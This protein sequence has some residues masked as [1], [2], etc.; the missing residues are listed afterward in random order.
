MKIALLHG[1]LVNSGDFLIAQRSKELLKFIY[2][3]ALITEYYRN[4]SI[5]PYLTDINNHNIMIIAGGPVYINE[6]Y[7]EG[8]LLIP[9]LSL[10]KIPIMFLGMGWWGPTNL[11]T[12][13]YNY[14][15]SGP[16]LD[17]L[18]RASNDTKCLTCRDNLTTSVIRINGFD[19]VIDF[20]LPKQPSFQF[21]SIDDK[22][23]ATPEVDS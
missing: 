23:N 7:P 6:F 4:Q 14:S 18:K 21:T 11:P 12:V 3:D 10:I 2:T 15:F 22:A 8:S 16:M 19:N 5:E 13:M 20:M 1:A 9:E 17:L